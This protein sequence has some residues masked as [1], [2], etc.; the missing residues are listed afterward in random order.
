[1]CRFCS[2][3]G[4]SDTYRSF[5]AA[6]QA[7]NIRLPSRSPF[8]D[9][10]VEDPGEVYSPMP[11]K[12]G[13]RVY[14]TEPLS[15][16]RERTERWYRN[17]RERTELRRRFESEVKPYARQLVGEL[18]ALLDQS[19]EE[20]IKRRGGDW[21]CSFVLFVVERVLYYERVLPTAGN[22][23]TLFAA[24]ACYLDLDVGGISQRKICRQLRVARN[25]LDPWTAALDDFEE[26]TDASYKTKPDDLEDPASS[27]DSDTYGYYTREE[28]EEFL[29]EA[30]I[31][32]LGVAR[33]SCA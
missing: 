28:W 13:K 12:T 33:K 23:R 19:K 2:T 29:T 7:M 5:L 4:S 27:D 22:L 10:D 1:M 3:K 8:D 25:I 15:G 32:T 9:F 16:A 14:P 20:A 11:S 30:G 26:Q 6:F 21:V 31:S 24:A 18:Q 17:E